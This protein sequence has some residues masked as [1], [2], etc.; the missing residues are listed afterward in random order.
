ME[1][2]CVRTTAEWDA[3][4]PEWD[5]LFSRS[6]VQVP[7][8]RFGY[9][10]AWWQSLGGAEWPPE[11][12]ALRIIT[13]RER[14]E[15]VGIAPLFLS[16]KPEWPPALRLIGSVEVSDYLDLLS[17]P[18]R[19][20]DFLTGLLAFLQG[21]PELRGYP[22]ELLNLREDSTTLQMLPAAAESSGYTYTEER[23][24]PSPYIS[25]AESWE[26]YLAGVNK[27]QRHEIRRK[28][29]N[30]ENRHQTDWY[31]V[32]DA[33]RLEE[34]VDD[35]LAMMR[36]DPRKAAFLNPAMREHLQATARF[37]F[38]QGQLHLAFLT[39]EGH[40]AA[41][42]FS[43]IE[44]GKLW[45]YNSA[46]EP[47]YAPCSPG[48]VLLARVIEWAIAHG[49]REVDMMRG[50]EDYKYKFGAVNRYVTKVCCLPPL[51]A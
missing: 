21:D 46:W 44:G 30:A 12:S 23:L 47:A 34:E 7:F 4:A 43:F 2:S 20:A 3:L 29:R 28:V 49:L 14:G 5:L 38:G 51:P 9:L 16:S 13:A 22:L 31:S 27:K 40:K 8:L 15:L 32:Q 36:Q 11:K 33:S 48:W 10:R 50:D 41:A 19:L 18:K 1:F 42:Y 24:Q 35:F 37:A 26:A 25:L 6:H 17:P 39:F 45:V